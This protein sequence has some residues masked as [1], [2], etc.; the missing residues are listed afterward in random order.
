MENS[1]R[2]LLFCDAEPVWR[3]VLGSIVLLYVA[4]VENICRK[5]LFCDAEPVSR[6]VLGRYCFVICSQCGEQFQE[7]IVL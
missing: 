3:T 1:F 4:S 6:T 7:G 2:N 5:V